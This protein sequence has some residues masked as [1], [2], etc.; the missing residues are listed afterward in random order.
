MA[1]PV[2]MAAEL[3][4]VLAPHVAFQFVDRRSLRPPDGVEGNRLMRA[5]AEAFDFEVQEAGIEG[6][7]EGRGRLGRPLV[8]EHSLIP[9]PHGEAIGLF[10]RRHGALG[11]GLDR[12]PVDL[13]ARLRGHDARLCPSGLQRTSRYRWRPG[14]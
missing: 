8:S 12:A 10:A 11:R 13:L 2:R 6:I 4:A 7:A 9:S 1:A 14:R 5:A 3:R